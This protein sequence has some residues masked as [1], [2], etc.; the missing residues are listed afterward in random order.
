MRDLQTVLIIARS[1]PE[2]A[3]IADTLSDQYDYR[4]LSADSVENARAS[5]ADAQVDIALVEYGEGK[6]LKFL[7]D[8]RVSHPDVIRILALEA[9][10]EIGQREMAPA[11]IYQLIRKPLDANQIGLMVERGLEARELARRHRLL[12]RE[13]KF[14]ANATGI[15]A[16]PILPMQPES[17]RFEKLVY[18]SEKLHNLSELARKAAKT[19]LPILIQGATGTGKELLARAIHYN[20]GRRDSPLLVQNCGGMSDELLQSELFGHKRGAFTGAV[21]DRLGL[22]RAADRGTVF[23]DEISEVSS[24]FQVSLLRFL[25]EGEVKPLGSDKIVTSNVRIIAASNRPLRALVAA[26]KFRQDLYFRLRGFELE[27]PSLSDR[28]EDI[29]VLAEFFAAKHSEAMGRKI[30]GISAAVLEKLSAYDFPGNVRELENEIR[31]MVSLTEEG[32]YVTTTHM[33]PAIL[34]APPRSRFKSAGGYELRG[35]TLKEKVECL[36]KQVVAEVLSRHRWNQSKAANELGLSR[37]GLSNKIKRYSLD[38]A[39]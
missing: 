26:G 18:V 2:W 4:V 24:S 21:S 5:L 27:V 35:T 15:H 38:E 22:F 12:T 3:A 23:L 20:S 33:S 7:V 32:E 8:L 31:R 11:G 9:K 19:E 34:A 10:T 1:G 36:E 39:E 37:V 14:P 28:R 29:P 30:L 17:R 13:F 25:Q 16:R 6:G